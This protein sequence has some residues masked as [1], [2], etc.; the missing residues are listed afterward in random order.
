MHNFAWIATW[1]ITHRCNLRCVYC[2]HR[3]MSPA[4]S[5]EESDRRAIV[6]RLASYR[7]KFVN[8]SGGEP[9]LVEELPRLLARMKKEW[10][11]R[12][13][14]V[15][16]GTQP[17]KLVPLMENLDRIVVSID[18]PGEVNRRN[19]GIDGDGVLEKVGKLLPDARRHGVEIFFNCVITRHNVDG[20]SE[21]A[22]AVRAVSPDL[23]L[24]FSPV[25]PPERELSIL[26]SPETYT[27]FRREYENLRA[28]GYNV[29]QTFDNLLL[30]DNFSKIQCYNQYF[31]F[32]IDPEGRFTSCSMTMPDD[33]VTAVAKWRKLARPAGLRKA[34]DRIR[35]WL[36]GHAAGGIDF[37]C[38]TLCY[39]ESWLDVLFL[40]KTN[41][42]IPMY[43]RGLAKRMSEEDYAAAD[44]FVREHINPAFD[45]DLFKRRIAEAG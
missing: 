43:C 39:C 29:I 40:N 23:L 17:H 10:D 16:N 7:P 8:I 28:A 4:S 35:K 6:D 2:D 1:K 26:D 36:A 27:A 42:S 21:L 33:V 3:E 41:E 30:H 22:A 11:P 34:G 15:H 38:T 31:G 12:I 13:Y 24:C 45:I 14:V 44:S 32:R 20:I 25:I 19:R 9:T 37:I 18:G 5:V